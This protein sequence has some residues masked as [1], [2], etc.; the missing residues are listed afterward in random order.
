MPGFSTMLDRGASVAIGD[1]AG[2]FRTA[3]KRC[4]NAFSPPLDVA[5]SPLSAEAR[6]RDEPLVC[7][8][9]VAL[10]YIAWLLS[11][12]FVGCVPPL[13]FAEFV[14][15]FDLELAD[16]L[17]AEFGC[18]DCPSVRAELSLAVPVPV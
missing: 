2:D 4:C 8:L 16:P 6:L 17:P 3:D 1:A 15:W 14:G 12:P 13:E 11:L 9:K 5:V 7:V 18:W 10:G